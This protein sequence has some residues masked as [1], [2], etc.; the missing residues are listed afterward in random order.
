MRS[1]FVSQYTACDQRNDGSE[2]SQKRCEQHVVDDSLKATA[3]DIRSEAVGCDVAVGE[4]FLHQPTR[5]LF[6]LVDGVERA[7]A[8][9]TVYRL[10]HKI[11]VRR[12]SATGAV[13]HEFVA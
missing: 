6:E 7:V 9:L 11:P 3:N 10:L 5:G 13:P 1:D 2:A 8:L 12:S 4:C